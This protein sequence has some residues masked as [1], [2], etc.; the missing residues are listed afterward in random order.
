MIVVMGKVEVGLGWIDSEETIP[1]ESPTNPHCHGVGRDSASPKIG[2]GHPNVNW[3][4]HPNVT[5]SCYTSL[6]QL[7]VQSREAVNP[8]SNSRPTASPV[9]NAIPRA[10]QSADWGHW[11]VFAVI[12][13]FFVPDLQLLLLIGR[14]F[15]LLLY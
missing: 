1:T 10:S 15:L 2:R 11:L 12:C 14:L 9:P 5:T 3:V 4:L 13:S 7:Y 6:S 8:T